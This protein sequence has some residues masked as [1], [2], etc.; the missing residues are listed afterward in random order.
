MPSQSGDRPQANSSQP[1]SKTTRLSKRLTVGWA[2]P[3]AT[4]AESNTGEEYESRA[5]HRSSPR[6]K[7]SH[8]RSF[9][10]QD[11]EVNK[12]NT[13]SK[14]SSP[15][16]TASKPQLDHSSYYT[17]ASP[18]RGRRIPPRVPDAPTSRNLPATPRPQ[19]LPTPDLPD[20]D[21]NLRFPPLK[22]FE[23]R[24]LSKPTTLN[25]SSSK[26]EAQRKSPVWASCEAPGKPQADRQSPSSNGLYAIGESIIPWETEGKLCVMM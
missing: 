17:Y 6:R 25:S 10:K 5:N 22:D 9:K 23:M 12:A 14:M 21:A 7:T 4:D 2:T 16:S 8:P 24:K 26:M 15:S 18:A 11:S 3:L 19:R 13:L 1:Q 20:L